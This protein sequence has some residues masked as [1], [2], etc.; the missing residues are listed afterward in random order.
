MAN[1]DLSRLSAS[2]YPKLIQRWKNTAKT[3]YKRGSISVDGIDLVLGAE[4]DSLS[5]EFYLLPKPQTLEIVMRG[6][7]VGRRINWSMPMDDVPSDALVAYERFVRRAEETGEAGF[8][9][10]HKRFFL[11]EWKHFVDL[12]PGLES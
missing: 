6:L 3:P 2:D 9:R 11:E 5:I 4:T 12:F 10:R 8:A 1:V 7:Y